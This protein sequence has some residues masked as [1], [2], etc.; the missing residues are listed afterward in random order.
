MFVSEEQKCLGLVISRRRLDEG[1]PTD[2]DVRAS[3]DRRPSRRGALSCPR[4]HTP[5]HKRGGMLET[6]PASQWSLF[7][8]AISEEKN[9]KGIKWCDGS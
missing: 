1:E 2:D 3:I 7:S 8:M 9:E 5:E 4:M 6:T